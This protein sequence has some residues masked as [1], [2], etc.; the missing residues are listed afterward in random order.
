MNDADSQGR[1]W[2]PPFDRAIRRMTQA[3]DEV[4]AVVCAFLIVVTTIS[5]IVYQRGITIVWL[6]D[7]LRML[8]IWLVYLGSVSLCFHNDHIAMD[9]IYLRLSTRARANAQFRHRV[10]R[11][12]TVR[13]RQ[14]GSASS[15]MMTRD[16]LRHPAAERL[17]SVLAADARHPAVLRADDGGLSQL[18]LFG[19]D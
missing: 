12:R 1:G 3:A 9:A 16:R 18:S 7:V 13:L 10:A 2:L 11:H 8:L 15:S 17:P 6:D 5:V 14:P 19:C 4:A